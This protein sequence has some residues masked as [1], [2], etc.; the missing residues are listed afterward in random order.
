MHLKYK[1]WDG[2]R[3]TS[4]IELLLKTYCVFF[5]CSYLFASHR[6][7]RRTISL[8]IQLAGEMRAHITLETQ[9][10]ETSEA[11]RQSL[12]QNEKLKEVSLIAKLFVLYHSCWDL[13]SCF[14]HTPGLGHG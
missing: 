9:V 11:A 7:L 3:K 6:I 14:R 10:A 1:N 8:I 5:T 12:V 2:F 13:K 4:S